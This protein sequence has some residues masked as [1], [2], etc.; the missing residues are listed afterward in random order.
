MYRLSSRAAAV[1]I[2]VLLTALTACEDRPSPT[3]PIQGVETQSPE[4]RFAVGD[5]LT[6][7]NL[8]GGTEVGSLRWAVSQV[9]GGE[10]IRFAPG[11]A[12]QTITVDATILLDPHVTIE[13]PADKGITI[14][15]GGRVRVFLLGGADH[16]YVLRNLTIADGSAPGESG[17]G[18]LGP[19]AVLRLEHSTLTGNVARLSPA[20]QVKAATLVNTTVSGNRLADVADSYAA[21]LATDLTLVNSTIAHNASSGVNGIVTLRNSIIANHGSR[22]NCLSAVIEHEGQNIVDDYTCGASIV[23]DPLLGPLADNGGPTKTHAL[24]AGSPAINA[25]SD[26]TVTVDQRYKPRDAQCDIGAFEFTDYLATIALTMASSG[27]VDAGNGAAVLTGT[28]RCPGDETFD[29]KVELVQ[30]QKRGRSTIDVY[31]F[32]T[33]PIACTTSVQP[34]RVELVSAGDPFQRGGAQASAI[35]VN[36]APETT[37]AS[38]AQAVRLFKTRK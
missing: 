27:T 13:G 17:A 14:S 9:T 6:V 19:F 37:P 29:L 8:S 5:V 10:V 35:T 15:G 12:G 38:L 20:L 33:T 16:E 28:V 30:L 11:L 26:C 24:A 21:V 23:T 4:P 22:S 2:G 1:T 3:A 31:G 32:A 25:G 18:I 7:T 36:V 34:W